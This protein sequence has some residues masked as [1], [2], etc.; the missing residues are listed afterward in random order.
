MV[1]HRQGR[2]RISALVGSVSTTKICGTDNDFNHPF[3]TG[4]SLHRIQPL[5]AS[6]YYQPVP[7]GQKPFSHRNA[8]AICFRVPEP[9]LADLV[10]IS[11]LTNVGGG[12]SQGKPGYPPGAT[13]AGSLCYIWFPDYWALSQSHLGSYS[14]AP[15]VMTRRAE[16]AYKYPA[17]LRNAAASASLPFFGLCLSDS[18]RRRVW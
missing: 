5:R 1:G 13:Q 3:G 6:G 16:K 9:I 15:K 7:P 18:Q 10:A 8:L 4:T 2:Y 17:C 11:G 12:I 14:R